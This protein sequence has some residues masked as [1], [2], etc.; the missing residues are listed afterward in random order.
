[1]YKYHEK[2]IDFLES[3]DYTY[4]DDELFRELP[5]QSLLKGEIDS[6]ASLMV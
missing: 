2:F 4:E 6:W 5:D 1:M 3:S